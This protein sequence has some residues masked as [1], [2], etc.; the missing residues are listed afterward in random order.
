[1]L[2]SGLLR[3]K[4]QPSLDVEPEL[5]ESLPEVSDDGTVFTFK[6]REGLQFASGRPLTAEDVKYSLD[7]MLDDET[8]GWGVTYYMDIKGAP[9]AVSGEADGVEGIR[10]LDER[11]IEIE[12]SQPIAPDWFMTLMAVPWT[13]VVDR[14]AVE[15]WGDEFRNHPAGSGPYVLE[16]YTPGQ[17]LIFEKNPNYWRQPDEPYADRVEIEVGVDTSVAALKIEKGEIHLA[18]GDPMSPAALEPFLKDPTWEPYID[19]QEDTGAHLLAL[20]A[21]EGL[22]ADLRVRQAI[23]HAIDK[24]KMIELIGGSAVPAKTLLAPEA[25]VWHDPTIPEYEYNPDRAQA[26]LEEAGVEPGT[27]VEFW[28]ANY[29]PW[30]EIAQAVQYDLSQVGL[31]AVTNLVQ[32]AAWYEA[33]AQHNPIVV[34]QWPM[35]LPDPAYI[36][37]GGFSCAAMYPDSCCNWSWVCNDEMEAKLEMARQEQNQEERVRL[38]QE[39]DRAV[40][41]EEAYWLPLYHPEYV[42]VH[43]PELGGFEISQVLSPGVSHFSQYWVVGGE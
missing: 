6:L 13:Y 36:F 30:A 43:S 16:E 10:V 38:Y 23:A 1:M 35:E 24:E 22:T 21:S 33:N 26:L 39:L 7:R 25:G 42:W 15:E 5:A 40:S 2:Y 27:T 32:R 8:G 20:D 19:R 18:A 4:Q 41:Y 11:T 3:F 31:N 34:N 17:L 14:E 29:Y 28:S 12:M 37:D 9:E